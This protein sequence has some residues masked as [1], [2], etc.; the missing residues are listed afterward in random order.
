LE[1]NT[2]YRDTIPLGKL[3]MDTVL[4]NRNKP[5]AILQRCK[6]VSIGEFLTLAFKFVDKTQPFGEPTKG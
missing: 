6:T 5:I 4:K 2:F 3:E 1:D